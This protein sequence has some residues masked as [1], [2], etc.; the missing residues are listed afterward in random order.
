MIG[1]LV[2]LA[3]SGDANAVY[4]GLRREGFI[5]AELEIDAQAVLDYLLPMLD[6]IANEEFKFTRSWLRGEARR[7]TSP[8][9][10]AFALGRQLNLPPAYLLIHRVTLGSIGVLCQLEATAPYRSILERGLPGYAAPATP[11]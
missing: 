4:E 3:L 11:D 1:R 8:R 2:R 9:S 6:P 10:P 7:I 5:K